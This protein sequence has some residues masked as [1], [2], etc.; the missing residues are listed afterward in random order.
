MNSSSAPVIVALPP[1]PVFL[2]GQDL[3]AISV[4]YVWLD[5][6]DRRKVRQRVS[7]DAG[8]ELCLSL[9]RGT[10]LVDGQV[11]LSDAE[12]HI[13]VRAKLQ[14]LLAISPTTLQE[15][16]RVA[17][18]LG[19]WHRPIQ[20]ARDGKL[21][22]EKDHPVVEWLERTQIPFAELDSPF[23]PNSIASSHNH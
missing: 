12:R 2:V 19:N 20:I 7:S 11:L 10:V 6:H 3:S 17:H 13:I 14:P 16:C 23:E 15:S 9:P 8:T 5:W 18:H 1:T 4:E 22:V 21:L